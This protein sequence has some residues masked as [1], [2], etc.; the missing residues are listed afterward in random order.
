MTQK[1]ESIICL[2]GKNEI[3][4]HGLNLLLKRVDKKNIRVLCNANDTGIDTWQPSL[5]KAA[6]D[7]DLRVISLE[8]CYNQDQVIFLSL[9]FDKI[10]APKNFLNARLYNIHFSYLPAYTWWA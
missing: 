6:R 8:E 10:I 1:N 2:A 9:E 5:L 3:A 7:H 4:I